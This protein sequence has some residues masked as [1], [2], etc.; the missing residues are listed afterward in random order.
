[1]KMKETSRFKCNPEKDELSDLHVVCP[2][3]WRGTSM[4]K[5]MADGRRFAKTKEVAYVTKITLKDS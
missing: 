5:I 1:M 4:S 3:R 2:A